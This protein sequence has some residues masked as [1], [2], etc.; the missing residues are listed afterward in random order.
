M[1]KIYLTLVYNENNF[2]KK[3][4]KQNLASLIYSFW[5]SISYN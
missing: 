1:I 4:E 5:I 2:D 3:N